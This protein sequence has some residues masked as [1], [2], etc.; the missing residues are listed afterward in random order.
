MPRFIR[1]NI[2]I[3]TTFIM[4]FVLLLGALNSQNNLLFLVVGLVG[5]V[6]TVSLLWSHLA[7]RAI[8][9][10][11]L[12]P[13][14][15]V[16]GQSMLIR[17]RITNRSRWLPVFNLVIEE[18][19][20]RGGATWPR[21]FPPARAWVM[22]LSPGE[23][24]HGDMVVWPALRGEVRF[25]RAVC[26][27]HF[28]FGLVRRHCRI[29]QPGHT[30]VYP[31][32]YPLRPGLL[33]R[34]AP[35]GPL[36]H[37]LSTRTGGGEDYFGLREYRPGD[38]VRQIAWKRSATI[39][40]LI[41]RERTKPSP[42]K[43]RIVLDLSRE[44]ESLAGDLKSTDDRTPRMLEEQA[45]ALTASIVAQGE[46][47]GYEVGLTVL[48]LPAPTTPL[49]RGHWH[50]EKI[51]STLASLD[52]DAER[53][54]KNRVPEAEKAG[55]VVVHAGRVHPDR[56][57]R[58]AWHISPLQIEHFVQPGT[59]TSPYRSTSTTPAAGGSRT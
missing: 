1:S 9:F 44:T 15:G 27:T 26:W 40:Q 56:F 43:L 29:S 53:R 16:V 12:D 48:G 34:I 54:P 59:S 18:T 46:L 7:S 23:S 25:D 8:E 24:L 28:P 45:I 41:I 30:L 22:H 14:H 58:D 6:A 11:R 50:I 39:D 19:P 13:Q 33:R 4:L 55:L 38:S 42:P 51:M 57:T 3:I 32:R 35:G 31:A 2:P 49:K 36:G 10:R 21:F 47:D 5:A 52:L 20:D 17:Y 37:R